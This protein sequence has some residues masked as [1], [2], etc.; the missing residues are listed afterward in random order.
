MRELFTFCPKCNDSGTPETCDECSSRAKLLKKLRA[1]DITRSPRRFMPQN[2]LGLENEIEFAHLICKMWA[3]GR[4]DLFCN[5]NLC[6]GEQTSEEVENILQRAEAVVKRTAEGRMP[7]GRELYWVCGNFS[8]NCKT[9]L[10]PESGVC[11]DC[12]YTTASYKLENR[13]WR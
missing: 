3:I 2:S 4:I 9:E 6:V 1:G 8:A 7:P 5:A 13:R 11:P 10:G 12:G